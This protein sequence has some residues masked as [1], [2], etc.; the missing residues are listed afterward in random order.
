MEKDWNRGTEVETEGLT[1]RQRHKAGRDWDRDRD[2]DKDIDRHR[3]RYRYKYTYRY[4]DT[5]RDRT[6]IQLQRQG[7][8]DGE[9]RYIKAWLNMFLT[10]MCVIFVML[11]LCT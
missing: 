1:E 5:D 6:G 4:R 9:L 11:Y 10:T 8:R 3:Y 2:K 7:Q